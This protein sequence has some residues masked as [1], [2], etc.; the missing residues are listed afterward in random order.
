MK[1][2]TTVILS[3]AIV[4]ALLYLFSLYSFGRTV[5]L[6]IDDVMC[7]AVDLDGDGQYTPA[8]DM[9]LK[10]LSSLIIGTWK[11]DRRWSCLLPP[12]ILVVHAER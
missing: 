9:M 10:S 2:I 8:E 1:N 11:Q 6:S 3:A 7:G 5:Q 4:A 12:V